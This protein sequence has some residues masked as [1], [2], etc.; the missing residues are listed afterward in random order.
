MPVELTVLSGGREG[1]TIHLN[2]DTFQIGDDPAAD[3]YFDSRRDPAGRGRLAL[4]VRE[5]AGWR[6]QNQGSG[7]LV[8]N[9]AVVTGRVPLRSGD[10]I[11][12]SDMGPDVRFSL[13]SAARHG[14]LPDVAEGASADETRVADSTQAE[15]GVPR[16]P[17]GGLL[18]W[19]AIAA[20]I[21]GL[22]ATTVVGLAVVFRLPNGPTPTDARTL[23]PPPSSAIDQGT[24]P[25][26]AYTQ[27]DI[28]DHSSQGTSPNSVASK[29]SVGGLPS[30]PSSEASAPTSPG[31]EAGVTGTGPALD[32]CQSAVAAVAPA[33]CLLTVET[34]DKSHCFPYGNACAIR[35][36]TL[37]TNS[38]LAVELMG[39]QLDGWQVK[40]IWPSDGQELS[41]REILVHEV[42]NA[43]ADAP[44]ERIYWELAILRLDGKR[45]AVASLAEPTELAEI[46][47]G[48]PL[49]WVGIPHR[50]LPRTR[51]DRP[52]V[53][54]ALTEVYLQT[55]LP[56]GAGAPSGGAPAL[57]HLTGTLPRNIYGSP[58]VNAAGHVVG[59]Y[60]EKAEP[61][62]ADAGSGPELHYA[63]LVTLARAYLAGQSLD[64]W[65][66]PVWPHSKTP[67][68]SRP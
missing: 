1:E 67:P 19:W 26:P 7:S 25:N 61:M 43:T 53:E 39:K 30:A 11:R 22:I 29:N 31:F 49:A 23:S 65:I 35:E 51:F 66:R 21:V 6:I 48:L 37:L 13:I 55:K 60:A 4:V 42:F 33:V 18:R 14:A 54:Q 68:P 45:A 62:Q 56:A 63:P 9:H 38:V 44:G 59:V 58:L 57:L 12:L 32:P 52:R 3:L 5:E 10:I 2:L 8:V 16:W 34:P 28:D 64:N 46:E 47:A 36:D 41:V 50:D 27:K 40:A 15:G 24:A 17:R 20:A